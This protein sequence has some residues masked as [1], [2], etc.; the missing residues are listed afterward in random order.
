MSA[1][2]SLWPA[3]TRSEPLEGRGPASSQLFPD[4]QILPTRRKKFELS[5]TIFRCVAHESS[6]GRIV[7]GL[8]KPKRHI[9]ENNQR[10]SGRH[11]PRQP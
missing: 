2:G 8:Q 10:R 9:F 7:R 5:D 3:M 4:A 1:T 6:K 11:H